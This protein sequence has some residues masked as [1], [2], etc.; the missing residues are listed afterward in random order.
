MD[1]T[2]GKIHDGG[3]DAGAPIAVVT[4]HD[5][6]ALAYLTAAPAVG[7]YVVVSELAD[8]PEGVA[9]GGIAILDREPLDPALRDALT[10]ACLLDDK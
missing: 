8:L 9:L 1:I 2:R 4:R 7:R 3:T 6:A 10:A 5:E